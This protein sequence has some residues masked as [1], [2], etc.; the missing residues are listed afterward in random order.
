MGGFSIVSDRPRS[1]SNLLPDTGLLNLVSSLEAD[2]P[3]MMESGVDESGVCHWGRRVTLHCSPYSMVLNPVQ[4][5][6]MQRIAVS[7]TPVT[8][9][10]GYAGTR[11]VGH[12]IC[13]YN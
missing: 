8:P 4:A 12:L 11:V 7:G 6:I 5:S 9:H 1:E 3:H 2:E 10:S 13:Q